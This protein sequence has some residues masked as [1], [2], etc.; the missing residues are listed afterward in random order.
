V[1]KR[2]LVVVVVA[3]AHLTLSSSPGLAQTTRRLTVEWQNAPLTQV[4]GAISRFSGRRIVLAPEVG[5]QTVTV[6]LR[7]VEWRVALD[8][9]L[10]Q[11]ALVAQTDSS[12]LMRI[13]RRAPD[14]GSVR[15]EPS[16]PLVQ[17]IP[18]E[19]SVH[20]EV[21]DWGGSGRPIVL[22]AGLGATAHD[23]ESFARLLTPTYHVF[24]ITRRGFGASSVPT[25]GYSADRLGDDVLAVADSLGLKRP[26]LAGHSLAGEELSSIGSRYP[27]RVA[28]LIY[29]DAA[30][31]YAFYNRERGNYRIDR[32]E[33][34]RR[35]EELEA[36]RGPDERRVISQLLETDLRAFE[37]S[38]R[39]R[40]AQLPPTPPDARPAA[41]PRVIGLTP[42]PAAAAIMAG[43]QR[44]SD[45]RA[46]AL[47][48]YALPK[49]TPPPVA[50]DST[51]LALWLASQAESVAQADAFERGVPGARVVRIPNADHVVFQS[52]PSDVLREIHAF[53]ARLPAP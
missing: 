31:P 22:L 52:H 3:L 42:S 29:L 26:V 1:A 27:E 35:L 13:Q 30:Y 50:R 32:N 19:R 41:P 10:R 36:A 53:I 17:F 38:I 45:I 16:A 49:Q 7:D 15:R 14:V 43:Q 34:R 9:I 48:I 51:L 12:D 2:Q 33:L 18:V 28:G 46:P 20:L 24:G 39:E 6:S 37:R 8:S 40:L 44:Y 23:F 5:E 47:A 25:T 11:N 21:I 4:V